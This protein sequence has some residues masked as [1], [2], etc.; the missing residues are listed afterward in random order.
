M[1]LR[2]GIFGPLADDIVL[3]F[4]SCRRVGILGLGKGLVLFGV[5]VLEFAVATL[6]SLLAF[7][8]LEIFSFLFF[9][10]NLFGV[11]GLFASGISIGKRL[12]QC[13]FVYDC[14]K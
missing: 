2:L 3:L 9:G 6:F 1:L 7:L 8:G 5:V 13:Q 11:R 12:C 10:S 14:W 4:V